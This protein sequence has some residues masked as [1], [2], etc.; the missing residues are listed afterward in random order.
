MMK[1]IKVAKRP[2]SQEEKS[3]LQAAINTLDPAHEHVDTEQLKEIMQMVMRN[4]LSKADVGTLRTAASE[5]LP[6]ESDSEG[7]HERWLAAM[8]PLML[9]Q[10]T[11]ASGKIPQPMET[12]VVSIVRIVL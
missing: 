8:A 2:L 1:L 7:G 6:N 11:H 9:K 5:D 12:Y 3:K 10:L 4:K